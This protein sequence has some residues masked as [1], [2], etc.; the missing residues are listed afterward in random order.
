MVQNSS[1]YVEIYSSTRDELDR[2]AQTGGILV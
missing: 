2:L 1:R